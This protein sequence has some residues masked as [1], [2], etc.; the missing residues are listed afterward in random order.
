MILL[1][2]KQYIREHGQVSSD[3]L[4]RH[5]DLS[6]DALDGLMAPLLQQGFIYRQTLTNKVCTT[7]CQTSCQVNSDYFYWSPYPLKPLAI[8]VKVNQ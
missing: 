6:K 5:F 8:K 4:T 3:S 7:G 2:L 1:E